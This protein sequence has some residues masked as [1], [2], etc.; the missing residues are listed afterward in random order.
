MVRNTKI[1]SV[2]PLP[3]LKPACSQCPFNGLPRS[4]RRTLQKIFPDTDRRLM[5]LQ[6]PHADRSPLFGSLTMMPLFHAS[7]TFS[8]SH[9]LLHSF[10]KDLAL[11]VGSAFNMSAVTLSSPG[12][13]FPF[14]CLIA[15]SVSCCV[16][17]PL[18]IS[19]WNPI[20]SMAASTSGSGLFNVS[21]KCSSH[22]SS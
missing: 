8:S 4:L 12:A 5:P 17:F 1:W 13:L 7:G 16:M 15:L 21:L 10:F 19:I 2:Q 3:R 9:T 22:L 20:S 6:L 11:V 18:V 14:V